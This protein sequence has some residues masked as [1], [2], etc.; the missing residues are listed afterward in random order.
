M[1]SENRLILKPPVRECHHISPM[2]VS[3]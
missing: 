3:V 1:I 2:D